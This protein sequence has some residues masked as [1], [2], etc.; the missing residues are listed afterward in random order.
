MTE[1]QMEAR[2]DNGAG[3]PADGQALGSSASRQISWYETFAYATRIAVQHGVQLG[4]GGLPIAG[5]QQWCGLPDDDARKLLSLI[6]GGV[7]E[8]LINDIHQET[9]QQAGADVHGGDDWS[10]L[11]PTVQRR[12]RID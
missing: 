3:T 12:H 11:A 9:L 4:H 5:T 6:M 8:A 10:W 2:P 7:R 1:Q